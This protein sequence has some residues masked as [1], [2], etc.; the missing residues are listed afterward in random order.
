MLN[1]KT[2]ALEKVVTAC[3]RAITAICVSPHD[4][5]LITIAS[6]GGD[7]SLWKAE[8][9]IMCSRLALQPNSQ[10]LLEWD[11]HS[12]DHCV[13]VINNPHVSILYWYGLYGM[14]K[15]C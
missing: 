1:A 8:E 5:N 3:E 6:I 12:P 2:F 13:I 11:P 14:T 4:H 7:V 9:E 10:M 15:H